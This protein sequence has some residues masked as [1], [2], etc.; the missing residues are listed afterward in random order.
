MSEGYNSHCGVLKWLPCLL[1]D[2]WWCNFQLPMSLNNEHFGLIQCCNE[3]YR[4]LVVIVSWQTVDHHHHHHHHQ[5]IK[6]HW[7][8]LSGNPKKG[9]SQYLFSTQTPPP[10]PHCPGTYSLPTHPSFPPALRK[11][12][13]IVKPLRTRRQRKLR[14]NLKCRVNQILF[15]L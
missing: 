13:N 6:L 11:K 8:C 7:L 12:N 15:Y 2:S 5:Y 14:I 1:C 10:P 3:T 4:K 9:R